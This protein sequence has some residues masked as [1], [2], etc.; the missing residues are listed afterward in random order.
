MR[1]KYHIK[2][3]SKTFLYPQQ[4]KD[5]YL[6]LTDKQKAYFKIVINT[7]ARINEILNV[8]PKDIVIERNI[9]I[10]RVTKCRK[11]DGEKRAE[12]RMISISSEFKE[13]LLRY[14]KTSQIKVNEPIVK[15]SKTGIQKI[16]KE[17]LLL[18]SNKHKDIIFNDYSSHNF[19]KTHGNWL[20]C[21]GIP[22]S[23][24][25]LR[26]G[27]NQKT[28]MK[29]YVSPNLFNQMDV[30]LIL[31]ELGDLYKNIRRE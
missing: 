7:G 28:M 12:P 8:T 18:L 9:L 10:F 25:C 21:I 3:N 13:W 23:E 5:F 22:D 2:E 6:L 29:H 4:F 30:A 19:R 15:F 11:A 1:E 31:D 14:I 20:R 16:I 24:I 27:H 17:K 26:L